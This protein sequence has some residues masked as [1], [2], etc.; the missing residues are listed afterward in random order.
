MWNE[1]DGGGSGDGGQGG[2]G[3]AGGGKPDGGDGGGSGG[4]ELHGLKS[5]LEKERGQVKELRQEM[6]ELRELAA[7]AKDG[8]KAQE[9]LKAVQEKLNRYEFKEKRS[10]ALAKAIAEATKDGKSTVD[11]AKARKLAAK[12][13]SAD[14]LDQDVAE[15]VEVLLTPVAK[16]DGDEDEEE[17]GK[18]TTKKGKAMKGQP[19]KGGGEGRTTELPHSEWAKLKREDPE[20]YATMIAERRKKK[21]FSVL[22]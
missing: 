11:E 1:G 20:A 7:K 18:G 21:K 3:G 13:G 17:E 5:A 16:K 15:I 6:K 4:D 8:E 10:E 2:D 12:L 9:D 19:P 22:G 14:S